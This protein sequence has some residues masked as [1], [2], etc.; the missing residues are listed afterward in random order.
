MLQIPMTKS[1]C[2]SFVIKLL[3]R[4]TVE[5]VLCIIVPGSETIT[6]IAMYHRVST[7]LQ[8]YWTSELLTDFFYVLLT[9]F[10]NL[11]GSIAYLCIFKQNILQVMSWTHIPTLKFPHN[12]LQIVV[13]SHVSLYPVSMCICCLIIFSHILDYC[14]VS[15][16]LLQAK[17]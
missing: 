8:K 2:I 4:E 9:S 13:V 10:F 15:F 12:C 11:L 1:A 5:L 14:C 16:V 7:K 6:S 17:K 3:I